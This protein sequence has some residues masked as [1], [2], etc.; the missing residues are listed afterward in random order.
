MENLLLLAMSMASLM[1][2]GRLGPAAM[3]GVGIANQVAMLLQVLFMGL[4]VGNLALVARATGSG[5]VGA[6]QAAARQSLLLGGAL[7]LLL[8]AV[9]LPI[10]PLIL[11]IFGATPEVVANGT[12]YLRAIVL[13]LPLLGL[14]VLANGTLRGA[15]DTRTPMWSTGAANLANVA[16]AFP[17]IFGA[18][19][20]PALGLT[21]AAL[22][23]VAGRV[24]ATSLSFLALAT[25]RGGPLAGVMG[26]PAL[27]RPDP[28]V[29]RRLLGIGGPAALESGSIQVGML[30]FS[31]M[32]IQLGTAAFAAQQVVFNAASLSMLPGQAFAVAATTL[33][34]QRLGAFDVR[35]AARAGW[36]STAAAAGWMSLA[37][38]GFI[39]FP[40][41]ILRLYT[42]DPAV[43]AAGVAGIRVVGLGQPLQAAAFV[44][45]G[46]LRG[47]GDTRTTL[48]VGGIS[49]WGV[50]L[51]CA[52]VFGLLLGWGIPGIWIGWSA[53]W[54]VR[55]VAFLIAFSHGRWKRAV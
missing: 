9:C 49:M 6:A 23:L 10:V 19:P 8:V 45:G 22:G 42:T 51:T 30:V 52:Y 15:G 35:G 55:G 44:L 32:V 5:Q 17:L 27:W 24:L 41:P 28:A 48:L 34:G 33:V 31:T 47:A 46:A 54:C 37:G 43:I 53:D 4:S 3:A 13:T 7:S 14:G 12:V 36:H 16:V 29:L 1:M 39:L 21:G 11:S 50:R 20:I 2:V 38:L 18:G 26:R 25:R 40:E